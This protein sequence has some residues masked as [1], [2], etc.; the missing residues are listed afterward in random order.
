MLAA[1]ALVGPGLAPRQAEP[2]AHDPEPYQRVVAG[3]ESDAV[4]LEMNVRE[5]KP[6]KP[7]QPT[8]YLAAA[9]HIGEA[10]FYKSLQQFLDAQDVV[11]FESVKPP[12]A[13]DAAYDIGGPLDDAGKAKV[14]RQRLR[15]V[16]MG[17]EHYRAA[18]G[19]YP[20]DL[21]A[22]GNGGGRLAA[23]LG[24]TISDGWGHA[25]MYTL[26][27]GEP[28]VFDIVSLGSDGA[29][30]G[31][32]A[33]ADLRFSDQKPLSKAESG[34]RDDGLQAT[35]ARSMG[36]VFQLDV[37][38]HD[39]PNWRN[40]DLSIDQVQARLDQSGASA[41][42]LFRML[43]GSSMF[44]GVAK[45]LLGVMSASP[46]SRAALR[47]MMIEM[48]GQADD[49]FS[50]MPKNMNA[51]MKVIL[52]DRNRVVVGDLRRLIMNEPGVKTVG[53]IYGAGHLPGIETALVTELGYTPAGD[54][55]RPAMSVDAKSAGMTSAQFD[56]TRKTL[57]RMVERQINQ[58]KKAQKN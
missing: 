2:P 14:T 1:L 17:V 58:A 57:S 33:A 8:V 11:L 7:D 18:Q 12:G 31:D 15:L 10:S 3:G 4:R 20:V 39:K 49:L 32:G 21:A 35:L 47:L 52:D 22:L 51:M 43:D 55:W 28:A 37:M 46:E 54:S 24:G 50:A 25:L 19:A 6:S 13:G 53:I 23:L 45:F 44:T 9:V 36:L 30:G 38:N 16:A 34:D 5:F 41:D 26:K 56:Q 40:S 27:P 48:L 29:E 42:G